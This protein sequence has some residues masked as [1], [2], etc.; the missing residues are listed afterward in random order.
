[1]ESA[2]AGAERPV[3]ELAACP[4]P[5][6]KW[7]AGEM[8]VLPEAA[9]MSVPAETRQRYGSIDEE[10]AEMYTDGSKREGAQAVGA[11]VVTKQQNNWEE[12]TFS[13][14][15]G[16]TIFTAEA[17]AVAEAL[18]LYSQSG[19]G[20]R[21][22]VYS[23]SASVLKVLEAAKNKDIKDI[24]KMKRGE[25][26]AKIMKE[27][28][29]IYLMKN[30][31][32]NETVNRKKTPV[33]FVWVPAHRG[34]AGNE[35]ADAAAKRATEQTPNCEYALPYEDMLVNLVRNAWKEFATEMRNEARYKDVKYFSEIDTNKQRR[36][37]WFEKFVTQDRRTISVLS[38]IRANHYN[39]SESLARKHVV[40]DHGCDCREHVEDLAHV[41][42]ECEKYDHIRDEFVAKMRE[43]GFSGR[44]QYQDLVRKERPAVCV[45]V[46][47]FLIKTG[48]II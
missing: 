6:I 21:L 4:E 10:F 47:R 22:L 17:V 29:E 28:C 19:D 46:A 9:L 13:M 30:L 48:R 27:L 8:M 36:K 12:N 34:I 7:R 20:R 44:P 26:V 1:M 37:P 45:A 5:W 31:P 40:E 23:D 3:V 38:R 32:L 39:L 14:N 15:P 11:A 43:K 24:V 2:R 18:R 16:A 35:R 41:L 42:W 33:V 25:I